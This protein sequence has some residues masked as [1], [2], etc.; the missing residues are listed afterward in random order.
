M[1]RLVSPRGVRLETDDVPD[2]PDHN[3]GPRLSLPIVIVRK[4]TNGRE[5]KYIFPRDDELPALIDRLEEERKASHSL[6]NF[7]NLSYAFVEDQD[8][9]SDVLN[10]GRIE[11]PKSQA[12]EVNEPKD[13]SIA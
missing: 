4:H 6:A 3:L 11:I 12:S 9:T 5:H 13:K 7:T 8:S 1:S 2:D 10:K